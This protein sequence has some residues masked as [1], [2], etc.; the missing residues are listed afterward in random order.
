MRQSQDKQRKFEKI[1]FAKT[2]KSQINKYNEHVFVQEKQQENTKL[3]FQTVT[4]FEII[5]S[6][7]KSLPRTKTYNHWERN[8]MSC[9][10]N[11]VKRA[12]EKKWKELCWE[13][14]WMSLIQH[15]LED[16]QNEQS[17]II[18]FLC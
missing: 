14:G 6:F 8:Q 10:S 13:N 9:E 7:E 11:E 5:S 18:D 2:R 15:S 17:D 12:K 4:S 3:H 1:F 16:S